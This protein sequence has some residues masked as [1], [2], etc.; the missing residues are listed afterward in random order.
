MQIPFEPREPPRQPLS[1]KCVPV[2]AVTWGTLLRQTKPVLAALVKQLMCLVFNGNQ[3]IILGNIGAV[4][5]MSSAVKHAWMET[6]LRCCC[7]WVDGFLAGFNCVF[8]FKA[9]DTTGVEED[10]RSP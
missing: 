1:I 7:S 9:V 2:T 5:R 4:G 6:R 8:F 10:S 3:T